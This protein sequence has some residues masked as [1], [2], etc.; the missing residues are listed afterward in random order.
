M[1]ILSRP[2][3]AQ[4]MLVGPNREGLCVG[5][6]APCRSP[7]LR[8]QEGEGGGS[9]AGEAGHTGAGEAHVGS[10]LRLNVHF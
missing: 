6:S 7:C 1:P 2:V 5:S 9:D 10:T 8:V 3:L 4:N